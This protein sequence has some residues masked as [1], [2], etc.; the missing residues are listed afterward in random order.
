M[1]T[2]RDG[3]ST[4][5][6]L[7]R[8]YRWWPLLLCAVWLVA[9]AVGLPWPALLLMLPCAVTPMLLQH[10]GVLRDGW[11]PAVLRLAALVVPLVVV[12]ALNP[13]YDRH[14]LNQGRPGVLTPREFW[15][16]VARAEIPALVVVEVALLALAAWA[17][18][19]E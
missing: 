15:S 4:A 9:V 5:P 13:R 12:G 11:A 1:T 19:R 2:P 3:S 16:H 10:R 7:L 18:R 14:G 17:G 6:S 8:R